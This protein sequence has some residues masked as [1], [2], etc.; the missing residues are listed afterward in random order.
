MGERPRLTYS[1][2]AGTLPLQVS[3]FQETQ[4]SGTATSTGTYNFTI[5]ATDQVNQTATLQAVDHGRPSRLALLTTS[6][7]SATVNIATTAQLQATGG[8]PLHYWGY[9][10]RFASEP[11]WLRSMGTGKLTYVAT[12]A[13][14]VQHS[15]LHLGKQLPTNRCRPHLPVTITP[16]KVC[17]WQAAIEKA[18]E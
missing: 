10:W 11:T 17:T 5:Q 4:L 3:S 13:W 7:P 2:S 6:L 14:Y 9:R 8:V 18:N 12:R 1:L 16:W 15:S